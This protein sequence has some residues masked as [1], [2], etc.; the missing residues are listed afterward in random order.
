MNHKRELK[1]T[2]T[3]ERRKTDRK[4]KVEFKNKDMKWT[5]NINRKL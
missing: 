3:G 1:K 2:F 4:G 5:L